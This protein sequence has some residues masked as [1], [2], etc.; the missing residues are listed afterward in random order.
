MLFYHQNQSNERLHKTFMKKLDE[1][2]HFPVDPCE[3]SENHKCDSYYTKEKEK[4]N[5]TKE[6]R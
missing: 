5:G 4:R 3:N 1:E 2:F 6:K